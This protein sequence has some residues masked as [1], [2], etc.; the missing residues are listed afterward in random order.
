MEY[1][2]RTL[3]VSQSRIAEAEHPTPDRHRPERKT[4][5]A[6]DPATDAVARLLVME[7]S[8][9][10]M[11]RFLAALER[12]LA[13]SLGTPRAQQRSKVRKP[14]MPLPPAGLAREAAGR[15]SAAPGA[16]PEAAP[17]S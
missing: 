8:L 7:Q 3:V 17:L 1:K 9:R 2:K 15:I 16:L 6:G 12:D 5:H 14:A 4:E 11:R 10:S 13:L